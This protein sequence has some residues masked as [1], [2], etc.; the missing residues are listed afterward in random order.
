MM[1]SDNRERKAFAVFQALRGRVPLTEEE[2]CK[3]CELDRAEFPEVISL[4]TERQIA[5]NDSAPIQRWHL[6]QVFL[7]S[8]RRLVPTDA[9]V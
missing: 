9:C 2:L 7:D 8:V 4:L 5:E 3:A 1:A 6:S